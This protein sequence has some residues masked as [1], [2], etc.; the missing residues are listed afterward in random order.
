MSP[1]GTASATV[2]PFIVVTAECTVR[3]G[4]G[5]LSAGLH[6]VRSLPLGS[7]TTA[8]SSTKAEQ[9]EQ[10]LRHR[11]ADEGGEAGWL[12]HAQPAATG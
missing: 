5:A 9:E 2:A 1:C 4:T 3:S 8:L 11:T 6:V 10:Q 7:A 12:M